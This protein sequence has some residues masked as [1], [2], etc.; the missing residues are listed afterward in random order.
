MT[1]VRTQVL[2]I[3]SLALYHWGIGLSLSLA[4]VYAESKDLGKEN[5][6]YRLLVLLV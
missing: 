1:K 5:S 2:A 6:D 3:A 4:F